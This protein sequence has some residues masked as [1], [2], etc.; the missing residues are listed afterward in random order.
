MSELRQN[1]VTKEWVI[2]ATERAG[3]P[4]RV[5]GRIE[6]HA[7]EAERHFDTLGSCVVCDTLRFETEQ[8]TR[9]V[10]ENDGFVAFVPYAAGADTG[11]QRSPGG[12]RTHAQGV[13]RMPDRS[14]GEQAGPARGDASCAAS[15]TGTEGYSQGSGVQDT[16]GD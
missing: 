15:S 12:V 14:I 13:R 3:K 4:N 1:L 7:H 16:G 9:M 6:S 11:Q 5:V 8:G 10:Y 2:I